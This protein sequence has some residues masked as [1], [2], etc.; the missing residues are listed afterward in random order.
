MS[1]DGSIHFL[2]G[3]S[4]IQLSDAAAHLHNRSR[5]GNDRKLT[6]LEFDKIDL[7]AGVQS[8]SHTN[9]DWDCDLAFGSHG[10]SGHEIPFKIHFTLLFTIILTFH[11]FPYFMVRI[12]LCQRL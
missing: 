10:C 3:R 9:L 2:D 8:K 7:I 6:L 11:W 4:V 1:P 12:L 5:P